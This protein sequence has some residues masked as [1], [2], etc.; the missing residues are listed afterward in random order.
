MSYG[1]AGDGTGLGRSGGPGRPR[2]A[3]PPAPAARPASPIRATDRD[4]D[5]TIAVLQACYT[6]GRLTRAEHDARV[7]QALAAQT[8]AQLDSLTADLPQRQGYPDAPVAPG[9]RHTNGFAV[10]SLI[11]GVAQPFTGMLSTIP[12][13]AFGHVARS[14]IKRTGDDGRSM[15]TWGLALGWTGLA[16]LVLLLLGIIAA[17]VA[18]SQTSGG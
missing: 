17:V 3:A 5:A 4:R 1:S 12:A 10:A 18:V 11:C 13:I 9:P 16:F 8:Y 14:Q 15:A 7:G 2:P 6:E